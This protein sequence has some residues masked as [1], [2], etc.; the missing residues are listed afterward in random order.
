MPVFSSPQDRAH[1]AL[2]GF[3]AV[4]YVAFIASGA[5][6]AEHAPARRPPGRVLFD[7][8][9]FAVVLCGLPLLAFPAA[10]LALPG[11]STLAFG[12]AASWALPTVLLSAIAFAVAYLAPKA[13]GD[14]LI[15]PQYLPARWTPFHVAL[16]VGG[17]GLYLFAYEAVF[18]GFL[19]AL[20]L[21][22][23]TATAVVTQTALYAFA[24][25]P[26]S[27]KETKGSLFFGLVASAMTLGWGTIWPAFL[28]HLALALGNDTSCVRA[29]RRADTEARPASLPA[30]KLA[31][32][33]PSL[34]TL[35]SP[36]T[37]RSGDRR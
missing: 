36:Q 34:R 28:V 33:P 22:V 13:A 14:L 26:K 32:V 24:H 11:A 10:G 2:V 27:L 5:L 3:L 1:A 6:P 15:Y 20:L 8:A 29:L 12:H 35:S 18:R 37:A 17:W 16:E 4:A 31:R 30:R 25:F 23:G 7:R 9:V 19:L 21:P